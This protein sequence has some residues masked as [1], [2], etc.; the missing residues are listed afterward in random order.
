MKRFEFK[1][2]SYRIKVIAEKTTNR[3]YK[4]ENKEE[5]ELSNMNHKS[6]NSE[7]VS[8]LSKVLP[9]LLNVLYRKD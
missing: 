7:D 9:N 8:N 6:L 3:E 2:L 5:I 4:V 1:I